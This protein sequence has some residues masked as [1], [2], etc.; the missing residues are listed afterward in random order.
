MQVNST[1]ELCRVYIQN[2]MYALQ[3]VDSYGNTVQERVDKA[4]VEVKEQL[5]KVEKRGRAGSLVEE[6]SLHTLEPASMTRQVYSL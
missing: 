4:L 5:S 1:N 6:L 3:E 2:V